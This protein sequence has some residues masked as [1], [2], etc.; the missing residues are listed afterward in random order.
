MLHPGL[1]LFVLWLL[2]QAVLLVRGDGGLTR[3]AVFPSQTKRPPQRIKQPW[4]T[5][6]RTLRP[7]LFGGRKGE[8]QKISCSRKEPTAQAHAESG[9]LEE[10]RRD[11][12]GSGQPSLDLYS[13]FA[14]ALVRAHL[15]NDF[16]RQRCMQQ[17]LREAQPQ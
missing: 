2:Q 8:P 13:Q 5:V 17:L 16:L 12:A 6:S 1:F 10:S 15:G 14:G 9:A 11:C 4:P 7:I 3:A